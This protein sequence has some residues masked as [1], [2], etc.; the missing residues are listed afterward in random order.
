MTRSDAL[1]PTSGADA[2]GWRATSAQGLLLARWTAGELAALWFTG[3]ARW[4]W[5]V[6]GLALVVGALS[7]PVDPGWPLVVLGVVLLVGAGAFRLTLAL[8]SM[9][10]RRLALPRRA[11]HLRAEG[12]AARRRL[13]A[14]LEHSGVPVSIRQTVG[15]LWA[16]LRGRR[17]HAGVTEDLRGFSARLVSTAELAHLRD[18]LAEASGH[19]IAA[20][21]APDA[22]ASLPPSSVPVDDPEDPRGDGSAGDGPGQPAGR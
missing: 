20:P 9:I 17:P 7:I 2:G 6:G 10:L 14:E 19:P 16:L 5:L 21:L 3:L 1:G 4:A 13:R 18:R 11:R 8:V 22:T 15:F 12:T